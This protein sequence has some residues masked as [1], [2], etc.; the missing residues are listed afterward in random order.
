MDSPFHCMT[1]LPAP[2]GLKVVRS[3]IARAQPI[4]PE[5]NS[6]VEGGQLALGSR[7]CELGTVQVVLRSPLLSEKGKASAFMLI[8]FSADNAP[9]SPVIEVTPPDNAA[10]A[11][12]SIPASRLVSARR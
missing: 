5:L 8:S 2:T 3:S 1:A 7:G 10:L 4:S 6:V 9:R 12:G 11:C